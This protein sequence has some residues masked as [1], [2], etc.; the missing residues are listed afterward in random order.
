MPR[1]RRVADIAVAVA[2]VALLAI[3]I[4]LR[5]SV[6]RAQVSVPSTY[7]TGAHG[8]AA[9][10]DFLAREGVHV[11]RYGDPLSQL[12]LPRGTLVIAGDYALLHVGAGE[13]P[14]RG[15]DAWVRGGG[16]L[17]IFGRLSP[18]R[19]N[20]FGAPDLIN[21][22]A[23]FARAGCGLRP[24]AIVVAG[25]FSQGAAQTCTRDRT[26]LLRVG[27]R[28]AVLA[29]RH[30]K[31]MV[32]FSTTPSV[33]DNEH[34]AQRANAQFAYAVLGGRPVMFDERI[35][36]YV[37]ARSFW[38]VL[39]FPM[40]VAIV[41]ACTGVLL[42]VIGANLPFAPPQPSAPAD[43]RDSSEYI[44]SL[45]RMLERGGAQRAIVQR[46]CAHIQTVL[47][48]RSLADG[49]AR[50]LLERARALGSLAGPRAEDVM[51]AGRLFAMVRK[52]YRC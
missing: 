13:R 43:E 18:R 16:T 36:G 28:A 2:A 33:L 38:Q 42:A 24:T 41:V 3:L 30:G 21:I 50:D 34:L 10:Y 17:A 12:F 47:G 22:H 29:Y 48:P 6:E 1:N 37:N 23:T 7:D 45:A 20:R 51:A 46:L 35:Y 31:G 52:E 8:Y 27:N 14:V 26:T 39:P 19:D 40:R 4:A 15:L 9:V 11:T 32:I 49:R 25:A 44:A 5:A